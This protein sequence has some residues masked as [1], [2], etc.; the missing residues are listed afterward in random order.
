MPCSF[1]TRQKV[2]PINNNKN[3]SF[4]NPDSHIFITIKNNRL[5]HLLHLNKFQD[6]TKVTV[7]PTDTPVQTVQP[8][9]INYDK[10]SDHL[11]KHEAK[12]KDYN[13]EFTFRHSFKIVEDFDSS[14]TSVIYRNKIKIEEQPELNK[15]PSESLQSSLPLLFFI[16]G[17]GGNSKIW[18]NQLEY[19]YNQN[20]EIVAIDLLG[21]GQSGT[22]G[23]K[24]N[25]EF[26]EM[27]MDV[28]FVFD[29]F[30]KA[31]NVVIGHSY[32]CS[33]AQYLS[34]CR[35]E[36]VS[37]LVLISGGSPHPLDFKSPFLSFPLCF[38]HIIQPMIN[39]HF[40]W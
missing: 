7:D 22:S 14:G 9:H 4:L 25:F 33:F 6:S 2:E 31:N 20:Y 34:Q 21:H 38:M 39:C 36:V 32:G 19:F 17:V 24:V 12:T 1:C 5:F 37:R 23:D 29:M 11:V 18:L 13:T 15:N 28:V 27:A 35:P 8:T 26:K 16:H 40:F 30:S 3:N 10:W